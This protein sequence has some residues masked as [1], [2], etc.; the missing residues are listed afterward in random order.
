MHI[1]KEE[2]K[3]SPFVEDVTA[4]VVSPKEIC[5]PLELH[6]SPSMS[7]NLGAT[8]KKTTFLH[9]NKEYLE[10][11]IKI[12]AFVNGQKSKIVTYNRVC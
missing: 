10:T 6:V 4:H 3:F 2:R 7:Q 1:R 8:D 5:R 11:K 12:I 9:S